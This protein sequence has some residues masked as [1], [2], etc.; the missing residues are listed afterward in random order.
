MKEAN[1]TYKNET[2]IIWQIKHK[3]RTFY[4]DNVSADM[5]DDGI[6]G[7][8]RHIENSDTENLKTRVIK[9]TVKE[10]LVKL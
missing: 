5:F 8:K 9:R 10:D 1:G 6:E 2:K 3:S 7:L 4:S